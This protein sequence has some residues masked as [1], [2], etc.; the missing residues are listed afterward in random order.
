MTFLKIIFQKESIDFQEKS[1]LE[2]TYSIYYRLLENNS[3]VDKFI[4]IIQHIHSRPNVYTKYNNV[5]I[6]LGKKEEIMRDKYNELMENIDK[7]HSENNNGYKFQY[8]FDLSN[9]NQFILNDLHT[10]F[11]TFLVIFTQGM[12]TNEKNRKQIHLENEYNYAKIKEY[13]NQIN[14][15]I[16]NLECVLSTKA[17]TFSS[18]FFSSFLYS[19]PYRQP[20]P[21]EENEYSYFTVNSHWGDLLLGYGTT[22]K[23]LYHIFK[24]NDIKL[25]ENQFNLSPQRYVTSNIMGMFSET[26]ETHPEDYIKWCQENQILE[27]YNIDVHDKKNASGYI[28]LGDLVMD[29][30]ESR[31]DLLNRLILYKKIVSYSICDTIP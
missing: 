13:L 14:C 6:H 4:N 28:K 19:S 15:L 12:L 18:G 31:E 22:G 10:E 23:S 3:I 29:T 2:E 7:F 25:L 1:D 21:L 27:K 17:E 24:D 26:D 11:E 5:C 20:I 8:V 9:I 16:H 30:S